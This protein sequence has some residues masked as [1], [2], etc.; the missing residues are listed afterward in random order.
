MAF[1][2]ILDA[3]HS[4]L[5]ARVSILMPPLAAVYAPTVARAASLVSEPIFT[6]LPPDP[7][8]IMRLAACFETMNAL[9]RLV[10]ITRCQSLSSSST[11]GLR[12][13]M[14]A[15][16]MT[17]SILTPSLSHCAN[18]SATACSSVTSKARPWASNPLLLRRPAASA[19]VSARVPFRITLAPAVASPS[20]SAKPMPRAEPVTSAVRPL[21]SNSCVIRCSFPGVQVRDASAPLATGTPVAITVMSNPLVKT[22]DGRV[23]GDEI[24]R[25]AV[26]EVLLRALDEREN[27]LLRSRRI[28]CLDRDAKRFVHR[29]R[30][31]RAAGNF[32]AEFKARAQD[33]RQ[34]VLHL[35]D[36]LVVAGGE[37]RAV[38]REVG[39]NVFAL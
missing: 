9:V 18:A 17:M 15:L 1:A 37:D 4:A 6:I 25:G 26:F 29:Q 10:S 13:W 32:G 38:E 34:R 30:T 19:T 2:W 27:R 11:S 22:S 39:G 33:R 14:P 36:E 7:R 3:A 16:L 31:G 20:A 24:Q 8:A 23:V 28:A 12:N 35:L 5:I 21:K